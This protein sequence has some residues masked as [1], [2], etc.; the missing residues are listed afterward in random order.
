M[1]KVLEVHISSF[2]QFLQQ[3]ENGL[4]FLA[5]FSFILFVAVFTWK[6][7]TKHKLAECFFLRRLDLSPQLHENEMSCSNC[8]HTAPP[9]QAT[10]QFHWLE[11]SL[12]ICISADVIL[13]RKESYFHRK[14]FSPSPFFFFFMNFK[15]VR[16]GPAQ[17]P[18]CPFPV[19]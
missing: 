18:L 12:S 13:G 7:L 15:S 14:W 9:P 11:K 17:K 10:Y 1:K 2:L 19:S 6:T 3:E 5:L 4:L 16:T 8:R